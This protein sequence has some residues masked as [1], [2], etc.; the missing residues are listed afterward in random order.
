MV[1]CKCSSGD[2]W[3]TSSAECSQ[4]STFISL[5]SAG[6]IHAEAFSNSDAFVDLRAHRSQ[7]IKPQR[8]SLRGAHRYPLRCALSSPSTV[9]AK[10]NI[11]PNASVGAPNPGTNG[12][13]TKI[14]D[15]DSKGTLFQE[16]CF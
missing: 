12:T 3:T 4:C 9:E 7:A 16:Q 2:G 15:F 8:F 10:S 14:L 11:N 5:A 1:L 6:E 13:H